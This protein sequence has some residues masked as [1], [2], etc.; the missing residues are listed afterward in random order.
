MSKKAAPGA[1]SPMP[2]TGA[3]MYAKLVTQPALPSFA[4]SGASR[5]FNPSRLMNP[6]TECIATVTSSPWSASLV[7][8]SRTA[9]AS[10]KSVLLGGSQPQLRSVPMTT[11][12]PC[13]SSL[14]WTIEKLEGSP[15]SLGQWQWTDRPFWSSRRARLAR[16]KWYSTGKDREMPK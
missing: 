12:W 4:R 9:C 14:S 8:S 16:L 3:V 2:R 15:K 6:P 13:F 7:T 10:S 1:A 5:P 11:C